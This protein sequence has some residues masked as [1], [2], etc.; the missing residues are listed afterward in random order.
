MKKIII[1]IMV[2]AVVFLVWKY[3]IKDERGNDAQ[4]DQ[5]EEDGDEVIFDEALQ[6][7]EGAR[8]SLPSR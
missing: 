3:V 2:V 4:I 5:A 1:V 8:E 7:L 6:D